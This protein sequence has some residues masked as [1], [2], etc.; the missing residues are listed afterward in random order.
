MQD[1]SQTADVRQW[2][3]MADARSQANPIIA[4]YGS[5]KRAVGAV[6]AETLA[7]WFH[8]D[9]WTSGSLDAQVDNIPYI[10]LKD[11]Q[12]RSHPIIFATAV[13]GAYF[14][15]SLTLLINRQVAS[16]VG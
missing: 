7:I 4:H 13:T 5:N 2:N 12:L 14:A 1:R 16:L 6:L 3:E 8:Q 9:L 11:I 10:V 15:I